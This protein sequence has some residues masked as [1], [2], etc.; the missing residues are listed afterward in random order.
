MFILIFII[1]KLQLGN[2][3]SRIFD[4]PPMRSQRGRWERENEMTVI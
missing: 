4:H 2:P 1:P 3:Y